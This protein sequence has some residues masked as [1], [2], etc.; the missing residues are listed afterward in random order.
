MLFNY[1]QYDI[2][3]N[4]QVNFCSYLNLFRNTNTR[5]HM[6]HKR[7]NN[8][9]ISTRFNTFRTK[10]YFNYHLIF[11]IYLLWLELPT[12][13]E[14][15]IQVFFYLRQIICIW[16]YIFLIYIYFICIINLCLLILR[17]K[18]IDNIHLNCIFYLKKHIHTKQNLNSVQPAQ[19]NI[20]NVHYIPRGGDRQRLGLTSVYKM[21]MH[22]ITVQFCSGSWPTLP[23]E[24]QHLLFPIPKSCTFARNPMRFGTAMES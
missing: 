6:P 8:I 7:D 13:I 24:L 3:R 12:I 11:M 10:L 15:G 22:H 4:I 23:T 2:D 1:N 18:L 19:I 14:V 9:H 16:N 21:I 20:I 5:L 17:S